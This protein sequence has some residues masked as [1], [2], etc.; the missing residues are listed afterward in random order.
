MF[1][2]L[3]LTAVTVS[4]RGFDVLIVPFAFI[5]GIGVIIITPL[6]LF[7][8]WYFYRRR[9]KKHVITAQYESPLDLN[10]AELGYL[11]DG[12]LRDREVGATIIH[13]LQRGLLHI[14]KT[15]NGNRIFSGPRIDDNLRSYEKKLIE[16]ADIEGGI[17]GEDLLKRFIGIHTQDFN[18]PVATK[19]QVFTLLV[20]DD[21][22][23]KSYVKNRS[24]LA[25]LWGSWRISVFLCFVILYFP[26]ALLWG[27]QTLQSG[28]VDLLQLVMVLA[29]ATIISSVF[30][31]P[32]LI[33]G[34]ILNYYRG[35][36]VGREWMITPKLERLWPQIV[37]YRQYVQLVEAD[38]L[39]FDNDRLKKLSKNSAL[40]YAVALGFVK[41][42]RKMLS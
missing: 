2:A 7:R 18:I 11:F 27:Y 5:V 13:L 25:F 19:T 26:L 34:M 36:I 8:R 39:E 22:Q 16:E 17:S 38:R 32:F 1:A 40:S 3:F 15:D 6:A 31:I 23:K 42:W 9:L 24:L 28:T 20:H 12:K 35:S 37:G 4:L 14:K 33:V 41:N 21:L 10:P 29:L 30:F